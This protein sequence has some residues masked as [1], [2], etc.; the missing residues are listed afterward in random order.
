MSN[1]TLSASSVNSFLNC[2]RQWY[3]TYVLG[4]KGETSES[5]SVG[6]AVHDHAEMS[7]RTGQPTSFVATGEVKALSMV[8]EKE[9]MPDIGQA[10][11]IEEQFVLD[12]DGITYSGYIDYIDSQSRLRDLKTTARKPG[13]GKYRFNMVGYYLGATTMGWDV[14]ALGLDYIV[15]TKKPYYLPEWQPLPDEDEVAAWAGTLHQV[16]RGIEE[17][18]FP[19]TGLDGWACKWCAHQSICGPYQAM[20]EAIE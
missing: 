7:L 19:P 16:E 1:L 15:R 14:T 17:G 10:L 5:Q 8:F 9:V 12:I 18:D 13:P 3:I 6:L 4:I 11:H 2:P 20:K